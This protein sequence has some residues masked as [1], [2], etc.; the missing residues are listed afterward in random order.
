MTKDDISNQPRP[1]RTSQN[2]MS[3]VQSYHY[4]LGGRASTTM[5][6][7]RGCPEHCTFC[8]DAQTAVKWSSLDNLIMEME[9][10]KN[11]GYGGVYIF[12]DLFAIAKDKVEPI[13]KEL[14]KRDLIY[15]CNSQ[16]RYFTK[17]GEEFA[18]LLSDTGCYEIAFGAETGS[19]KILDNIEKRTTIDMNYKTVEY[20]N[21]HGII[22][23]AFMLLGLPGED[24]TTLKE[25]E[26]F[27]DF[28]M[29]NSVNGT[30][31]RNDFGAYVYMPFKGT[32]IRDS[33]DRGEEIGLK[34]LVPEVSGAYGVKGGE[35]SYEIQTKDLSAQ[36]LKEFRN[37]L[38]EKY[39]PVSSKEKW[40]NKFHDTHLVT[41][42]E[43]GDLIDLDDPN[44][45]NGEQ[46]KL[47]GKNK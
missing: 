3:I 14:Y 34:M 7:S 2:A 16:A 36:S 42:V 15:R 22:V 19:Q 6:T 1:D 17:W 38:V 24:E 28:L 25:T 29:N 23:K 41:N 44:N 11:L 27:I 13:V 47:I 43:Y 8:E 5:M 9:D 46:S 10:I 40:K 26:T 12:D 37:Y 45:G 32:Y 33:L 21:K 31:K 4:S 30:D 39:R 20:A 35:T 18:K